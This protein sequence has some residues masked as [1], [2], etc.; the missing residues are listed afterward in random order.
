MIF[1]AARQGDEAALRVVEEIG[2]INAVGVADVVNAYDPELV[3][4]G[5][6]VALNNPELVLEPIKRYVAGHVINRLPE[7]MI[8]PLGEDIVLYGALALALETE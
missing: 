1:D 4:I 2:K 5:G 7:I 6:S 3:T 8:T